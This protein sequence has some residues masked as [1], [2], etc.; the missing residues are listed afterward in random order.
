MDEKLR[1]ARLVTPG[2]I[3]ADELEA[4]GWTQRDLAAIMGW[5]EQAICEIM[6]ARQ[7]IT[8][9]TARELAQAFGTSAELWLNLETNYRQWRRGPYRA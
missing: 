4:R 9:K 5:P 1:P 2:R 3:I 7:E 8:P 6:S